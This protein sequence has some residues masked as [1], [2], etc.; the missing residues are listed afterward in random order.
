MSRNGAMMSRK[1]PCGSS[2][3]TQIASKF[4]NRRFVS[5]LVLL[6]I[7]CKNWSWPLKQPRI[8]LNTSYECCL[9]ATTSS[10]PTCPLA[11]PLPNA[12]NIRHYPLFL[13]LLNATTVNE[14]LM[15]IQEGN[16]ASG[17]VHWTVHTAT[18][19]RLQWLGVCVQDSHELCT[20]V[21]CKSSC[22]SLRFCTAYSLILHPDPSVAFCLLLK[23]TTCLGCQLPRQ[24]RSW[25]TCLIVIVK[26]FIASAQTLLFC[27]DCGN[28][29]YFVKSKQ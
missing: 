19:C 3:W 29:K 11:I 21:Q 5:K 9:T 2:S 16:N 13:M 14:L 27:N 26:V 17:Q 24:Q 23:S 18:L 6:P 1:R 28:F 8:I 4:C 20:T 7:I 10:R 15:W 12:I 25:I 22:N